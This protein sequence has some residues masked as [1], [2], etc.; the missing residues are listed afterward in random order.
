MV[1]VLD[2]P[3]C[4]EAQVQMLTEMVGK[5]QEARKLL[6]KTCRLA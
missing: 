5:A 6:D 1:M 4:N 3:D 2:S